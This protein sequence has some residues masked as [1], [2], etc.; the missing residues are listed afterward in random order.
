M[1]CEWCMALIATAATFLLPKV[2]KAQPETINQYLAEVYFFIFVDL[3]FSD[4]RVSE[5]FGIKP[6]TVALPHRLQSFQLQ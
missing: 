2:T 1:V 6:R 5:D 3:F 4:V